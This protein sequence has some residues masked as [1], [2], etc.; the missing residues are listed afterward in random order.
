MEKNI[1]TIDRIKKI[2]IVGPE[3]TGKS[4]LAKKLAIYYDTCWVKEYAR[5]YID[6][7]PIPYQKHDLSIIAKGQIESENNLIGQANRIL[8]CDTN[9]MVIKIWSE[10]KYGSCEEWILKEIHRRSY[11]LHLLTYIDIPWENDPQREHP[12]KRAYFY[13]I[14]KEELES[15]KFKYVEVKGGM[16]ER[17]R[18]A[19]SAINTLL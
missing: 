5:E 16:D 10:Y 3:S 12:D 18:C 6:N 7:L 4:T 15:Q 11:D 17:L 1:G 9:L 19:V 2:V 8:I 13:K 14:Y